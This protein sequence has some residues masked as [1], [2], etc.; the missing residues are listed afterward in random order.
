MGTRGGFGFHANGV[1]CVSYNHFDS[2]PTGLGKDLQDQISILMTE[3][4][5]EKFLFGAMQSEIIENLL[6][7]PQKDS[8]TILSPVTA[9]KLRDQLT[10]CEIA[11]GSVHGNKETPYNMMR[12]VQGTIYPYLRKQNPR[13][14]YMIDSREF[15]QESL[16][17]EYAYILNADTGM[18]EVYRG[19]NKDK[20]RQSKRFAIENPD[21]GY[22]GVRAYKAFSIKDFLELNMAEFERDMYKEEEAEA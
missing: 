21:D 14:G 12:N 16:F 15:L 9:M 5:D 18:V 3:W 11:V 20:K 1:D 13:L 7:I 19:F 10:E 6:L 22:Y 2:Y 8:D 4:E 17:C